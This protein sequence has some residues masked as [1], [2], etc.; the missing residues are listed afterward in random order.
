MASQESALPP[1]A[2]AGAPRVFVSYAWEDD[3][4]KTWVERLST[5]LRKDGVN[6][7]LDAWHC[8]SRTIPEFMNSE[9]RAADKV[10][11]VCSPKYR[12]KVHA[13]ED[14]E[15]ITG[16]GWE[17]MLVGSALF[18][19]LAGPSKIVVSL[20][21]GEW[22]KA[23]PDFLVGLPYFDLSAEERFESQYLELL[24][25]LLGKQE[26]APPIGTPPPNLEPTAVTPLGG[27][28]ESPPA[29]A[30]LRAALSAGDP[31]PE[32]DEKSLQS[33]LRHSPRSLDEYRL[34][35]IAEWSQPR[36]ALDKRFTRL[37]LLL[38]QGPQ[39][40]G[41]RWQAQARTFDDLREVLTHASEPAL[42]VLGPPG[43][44]KSTLLRRLELDLSLDALRTPSDDAV[45]SFFLPPLSPPATGRSASDARRVARAGMDAALSETARVPRTPAQ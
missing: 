40:E 25:A 15:R 7:R 39:A 42:V 11:I 12:E 5:R 32:L 14:G 41:M 31:A 38:D 34:A 44:G 9:A 24:R 8:R 28:P 27:R 2:G 26:A 10:L 20:A 16:S 30:T 36:Y 18:A 4:Y 1:T 6:V 21:R 33:I 37:T 13:M 23:A 35:R 22:G 17:A 19:G 45:L 3:E 29:L 43:C